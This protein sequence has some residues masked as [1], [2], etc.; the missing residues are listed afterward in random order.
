MRLSHGG[1]L[2]HGHPIN[3]SGK[4]FNIVDYGVDEKTGCIDYE[5]V[6]DIARREQPP[7]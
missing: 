6:R 2:T 7:A 3:L 4:W 1:H 5:K